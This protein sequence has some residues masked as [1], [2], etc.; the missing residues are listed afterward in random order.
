MKNSIEDYI[1]TLLYDCQKAIHD[2]LTEQYPYLLFYID[3]DLDISAWVKVN[4]HCGSAIK[5]KKYQR[6]TAGFRD[7]FWEELNEKVKPVATEPDKY[8]QCTECGRVL[9][10]EEYADFVMAADYCKDCAKKPDVAAS[11]AESHTRGFYD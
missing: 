8:F 3:N 7:S 5:L 4:G 2:K 9:P 6:S 10:K 1:Q 11:I